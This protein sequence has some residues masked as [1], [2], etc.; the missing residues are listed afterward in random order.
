MRSFVPVFVRIA[1][2][3]LVACALL[4]AGLC[5]AWCLMSAAAPAPHSCCHGKKSTGHEPCGQ[6]SSG[7]QALPQAAIVPVT[8]SLIPESSAIRFEPVDFGIVPV[9]ATQSNSP[10]LPRIF[11]VLR[12]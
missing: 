5:P 8:P 10:P 12:I 11:T 7:P 6:A 2:R 4:Y 9:S 3:I 1:V